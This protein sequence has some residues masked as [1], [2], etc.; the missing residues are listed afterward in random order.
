MIVI[1]EMIIIPLHKII[2]ILDAYIVN[3][4][5]LVCYDVLE[6][7][8][9]ISINKNIITRGINNRKNNQNFDRIIW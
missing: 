1:D 9:Y 6:Y 2:N 4:L 7:F 5:L 8:R 3:I